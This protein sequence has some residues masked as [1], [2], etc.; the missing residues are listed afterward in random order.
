ML[1]DAESSEGLQR[2]DTELMTALDKE[3]LDQPDNTPETNT[4]LLSVQDTELL[5]KRIDS[6]PKFSGKRNGENAG[7]FTDSLKKLPKTSSSKEEKKNS[8]PS[9][10]SGASGPEINS[11]GASSNFN[12]DSIFQNSR[13]AYKKSQEPET[14]KLTFR[15]R[16]EDKKSSP[17]KPL[18]E[19]VTEK[20]K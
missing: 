12:R 16:D 5:D 8:G 15:L 17:E 14:E 1:E 7:S 3:L 18:N 11:S 9:D 13:L 6:T 19:Q 2:M 20:T 4:P 10:K